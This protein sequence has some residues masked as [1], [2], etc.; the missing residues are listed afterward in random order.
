LSEYLSVSPNGA[1]TYDRSEWTFANGS[2]TCAFGSI[3]KYTGVFTRNS[4]IDT[5]K[6]PIKV[7][8]KVYQ[9]PDADGKER[10][11]L[12]ATCDLYFHERVA[13]PGDIVFN[14]GSFSDDLMSGKTPIG[15]CFYVDPKNKDRRLMVALNSIY[16]GSNP[17]YTK[18]G[19]A[20]GGE[21]ADN[22]GHVTGYYGTDP[23]CYTT[24][25][26]TLGYSCWDVASIPNYPIGSEVVDMDVQGQPAVIY[27]SDSIYR[28][29]SNTENNQFKSFTKQ[30]Y[31]GDI[32]W[33]VAN[34]DITIDRLT[35]PDNKT[36]LELKADTAVPS[37]YYNTLAII[38]HRNKV[39]N[40]YQN[41]DF[42]KRP[43]DWY[44]DGELQQSE[45]SMLNQF[46]SEAVSWDYE[47]RSGAI[48]QTFGDTLYYP[49]A[50]ACF[51][52]EPNVSNLDNKFKKYNWF[53][54]ASGDV[55]RILYYCYNAKY[56]VSDF[57]DA[58]AFKNAIDLNVLKLQ[59]FYDG[60][61]NNGI[62]TS[63]ESSITEF[64]NVI[65]KT[66]KWSPNA[67]S[68]G[69]IVRPICRF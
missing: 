12:D 66:G 5:N 46:V 16:A 26:E 4:E 44:A 54:P 23:G 55:V 42:F 56:D 6:N 61:S 17:S 24:L 47:S 11:V 57:D 40:E 65:S 30:T 59:N 1:N 62:V 64:F 9:I 60:V 39:L 20:S 28:D 50:S 48:A 19:M 3:D 33:K 68:N 63:T 18:W 69:G 49:A 32:G 21:N 27:L 51:A 15:V 8:I 22:S 31:F 2:T 14:D 67:K 58:K 41:G 45:L 53:L 13:K 34:K 38:E 35:L 52:Y 10:D 29:A 36:I 25:Y 43:Y 7:Y 37:G